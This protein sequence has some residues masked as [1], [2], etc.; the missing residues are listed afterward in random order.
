MT[1]NELMSIIK[2][3]VNNE[4]INKYNLE[5]VYTI[6]ADNFNKLDEHLHYTHNEG[7][8]KPSG[9]LIEIEVGG[10]IF[11]IKKLESLEN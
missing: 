11:K 5:L 1:Y 6:D 10:V 4:Y 7:E 3:V 9:E 2:D 8:F